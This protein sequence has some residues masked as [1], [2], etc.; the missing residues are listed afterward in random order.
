MKLKIILSMALASA[1]LAGCEE[2]EDLKPTEA[3]N[4]AA[5]RGIRGLVRAALDQPE[6]EFRGEIGEVRIFEHPQGKGFGRVSLSMI[7]KDGEEHLTTTIDLESPDE[8]ARLRR[9]GVSFSHNRTGLN[10]VLSEAEPSRVSYR[11]TVT[12]VMD[13]SRA[14]GSVTAEF[15][16]GARLSAKFEGAAPRV[17]CWSAGAAQG[18]GGFD[19]IAPPVSYRASSLDEPFCR[20]AQALLDLGG[21]LDS[22]TYR[23]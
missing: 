14:Q 10:H 1:A 21:R 5:E 18:L 23:H 2:A 6:R 16:D 11:G 20:D 22:V 15:G 9:E 4:D 12:L 19:E 3:A 7:M 13:R 17:S 8:L